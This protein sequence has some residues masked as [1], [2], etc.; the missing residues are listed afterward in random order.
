VCSTLAKISTIV[1]VTLAAPLRYSL[2]KRN[3]LLHLSI[4]F[5]TRHQ[6]WW[7][8]LVCFTLTNISTLVYVTLVAPLR[9]SL[10]K[11][12]NLLRVCVAYDAKKFCNI[13]PWKAK[14]ELCLKSLKKAFL[15]T[16][17]KTCKASQNGVGENWRKKAFKLKVR[18]WGI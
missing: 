2:V 7:I 11:R 15:S 12:N 17:Y 10:V 13:W 1:S 9:Y 16:L 4:A 6:L 14:R 18:A 3:N 8:K 5:D